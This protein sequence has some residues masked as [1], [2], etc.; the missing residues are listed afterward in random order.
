VVWLQVW[1]PPASDG[2]HVGIGVV[3]PAVGR[4]RG[5]GMVRQRSG[6]SAMS[7][8]RR[9]CTVCVHGKEERRF[10]HSVRVHRSAAHIQDD[11]RAQGQTV[12]GHIL[13]EAPTQQPSQVAGF[14]VPRNGHPA[15]HHTQQHAGCGRRVVAELYR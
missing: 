2:A 11:G 9:D 15:S 7:H 5:P 3:R 1:R 6:H 12:A 4:L 13:P 10:G 14:R 8:A